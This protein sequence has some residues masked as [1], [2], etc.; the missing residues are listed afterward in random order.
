MTIS[1]EIETASASMAA[2]A[3]SMLARTVKRSSPTMIATSTQPATKWSIATKPAT[4]ARSSPTSITVA[5]TSRRRLAPA[6]STIAAP[7]A[8]TIAANASGITRTMLVATI[9]TAI[10]GTGTPAL[11]TAAISGTTIATGK[12][13]AHRVRTMSAL[14]ATSV[15]RRTTRIAIPIKRSQI[16]NQTAETI[17]SSFGHLLKP[18]GPVLNPQGSVSGPPGSL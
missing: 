12:T 11:I 3:A 2:V 9:T 13:T 6:S 16:T 15:T 17:A 7:Y 5:L 4:I 1:T 14:N 10:F 8:A 18:S